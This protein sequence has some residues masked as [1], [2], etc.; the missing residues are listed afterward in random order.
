MATI[1]TLKG[2]R[3]RAKNTMGRAVEGVGA[4]LE[5]RQNLRGMTRDQLDDLL[6]ATASKILDV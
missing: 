1:G 2:T 6:H 5:D 3:T 4:I